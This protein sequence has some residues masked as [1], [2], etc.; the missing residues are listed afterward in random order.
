MLEDIYTI[1]LQKVGVNTTKVK[2]AQGRSTRTFEQFWAVK[3]EFF[4]FVVICNQ[5]F[6]TVSQTIPGRPLSE[7]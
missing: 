2:K 5:L 1:T 7:V 3:S 4:H 6:A